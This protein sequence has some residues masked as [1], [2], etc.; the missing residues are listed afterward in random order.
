MFCCFTPYTKVLN[1]HQSN[2]G[3]LKCG[4]ACSGNNAL[5]SQA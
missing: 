1:S 5:L 3:I 4:K 2:H